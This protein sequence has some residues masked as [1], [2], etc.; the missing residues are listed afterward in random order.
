MIDDKKFRNARYPCRYLLSTLEGTYIEKPS[1]P[2]D[3][4]VKKAILLNNAVLEL[5]IR[6]I[7]RIKEMLCDEMHIDMVNLRERISSN[8]S[9]QDNVFDL[10]VD[11]E[12]NSKK[13]ILKDEEVDEADLIICSLVYRDNKVFSSAMESI[14]EK[15]MH[16][17]AELGLKIYIVFNKQ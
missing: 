9:L 3:L 8:P 2:S 17:L 11:A 13:K 4:D 15:R 7:D 1:L 5:S 14:G 16:K 6:C 10:V 12:K